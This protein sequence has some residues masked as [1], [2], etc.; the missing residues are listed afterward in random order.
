MRDAI[1]GR[2][3]LSGR[4]RRSLHPGFAV[5]LLALMATACGSRKGVPLAARPTERPMAVAGL[6][7]VGK[8]SDAAGR[9]F[10]FVP[11]SA[12]STRDG[13]DGV[14]IVGGDS[15]VSFRWVAAGRLID[16][17]RVLLSGVD[18]GEC[19]VVRPMGALREGSKVTTVNQ[20][21][22]KGGGDNE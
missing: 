18:E 22:T 16:G 12:V 21:G 10:F 15:T 17:K 5:A 9:T 11:A 19:V 6:A 8:S 13:Y 14:W 2:S 7:P 20:N 1:C 3:I 4:I